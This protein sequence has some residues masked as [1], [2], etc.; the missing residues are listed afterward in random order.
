M[1]LNFIIGKIAWII[2]VSL[3]K[4]SYHWTK[5]KEFQEIKYCGTQWKTSLRE[6]RKRPLSENRHGGAG[7]KTA[8]LHS[9]SAQALNYKAESLLPLKLPHDF[10]AVKGLRANLN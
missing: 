5:A 6:K 9:S 8:R 10:P 7:H 4:K 1:E 2:R 3:F